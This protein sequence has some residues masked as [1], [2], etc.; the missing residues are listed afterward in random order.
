MLFIALFNCS[1]QYYGQQ[2]ANFYSYLYNDYKSYADYKR[3]NYD[4]KGAR[5]FTNKAKKIE[6]GQV[7]LPIDVPQNSNMTEFFSKDTT[8]SQLEDMRQRMFLV[9]NN[10]TSKIQYP[11][12]VANLQFYYD[13]WIIEESNYTKYSQLARCKQGFIDTLGYLE[14]KLLVL[15]KGER[16]L[17]IKE[18]DKSDYKPYHFVKPKKYVIN[19]D[20]DSSII[21]ED[22]SRVIW[23]FLN[24]LK[25]IDG[26]YVVKLK[27]HA[28]RKGNNEYNQKLSERRTETV[29]HYLVKN[30]VDES[31]IE[32][33]WNGE[34]DPRVVTRND[35]KESL[36]RRVVITVKMLD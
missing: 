24:D 35:F 27:G 33:S 2:E 18:I 16:D 8:P 22:S 14:F 6:K 15:T 4:W 31:K 5:V 28:D 23:Q 10:K 25:K 17:I 29:K 13:C 36:N 1:T 30:G 19:F 34:I 11:E 12:E 9:I 3:E 7:V 21:N 32:T 26:N 20:F